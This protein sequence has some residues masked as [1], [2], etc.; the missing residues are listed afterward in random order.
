MLLGLALVSGCSSGGD[1]FAELDPAPDPGKEDGVGRRGL[2]VNADYSSTQAWTV[3]NQ[4]EDRDTPAAQKAGIAWDA[5][6]GLSW[7]EKYAK[8]IGAFESIQAAG[9]SSYSGSNETV[10]ISTPFGG[11]SLPSP[12][13]DCADATIMFRATF[14]AWYQLPFYMVAGG[15][16]T[17][18]FGHFGIRTTA[19]QWSGAVALPAAHKDYSA[20][21]PAEWPKDPALRALHL[22]GK[23]TD[24]SYQDEMPYIV[25]KGEG[26]GAYLDELHLNKRAARLIWYMQQYMGSRNVVDTNNTYNLTPE[27][28]RTGDTLMYRRGPQGTGHTMVVIR[29]RPLDGGKMEAQDIFGNEPPDQL[30]VES[31]TATRYN[32]MSDEGGG[33]SMSEDGKTPYSHLGGGLKRWRVAKAVSG[34][35]MNTWM[36]SDEAS[37]IDS[38]DYARIEARPKA[39]AGLLGE[40]PPL[41][42]RD[43]LLKQIE[44]KRDHLRQYPASCAGR[45]HREELFNQLYALMYQHYGWTSAQVDAKYR[46]LEDYV[47]API[48]YLKS[49]TCCWNSSTN[50]MHKTIMA[51]AQSLQTKMC[52]VPPVFM[53][54]GNSFGVYEQYAQAQGMPFPAWRADEECPQA[55]NPDDTLEAYSPQRVGLCELSTQAPPSNDPDHPASTDGGDAV[56]LGGASD[57]PDL[58]T[59]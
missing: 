27:A 44:D 50:A 43:E 31:P 6:S 4:W 55:G 40:L 23:N 42:Q 7:D 15:N 28:L 38:S 47:Y 41:Q 18:Y 1:D 22:H 57:S 59:P 35:W 26:T 39:F 53:E 20:N 48:D 58:G 33:P 46:T 5:N 21:P 45:E 37:W 29:A 25:G 54:K 30:Y 13:L 12:K 56:D 19:G 51:Y 36:Q 9:S 32:F 24:G 14:A 3:V 16:P 52:A 34:Y 10:N 11:K 49:R 2:P 8:W 17:I